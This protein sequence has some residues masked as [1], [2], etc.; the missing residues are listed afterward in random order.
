MLLSVAPLPSHSPQNAPGFSCR[1]PSRRRTAEAEV[2]K[3]STF[4]SA[5]SLGFMRELNLSMFNV[6]FSISNWS[7]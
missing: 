5:P 4:L 6:Q 7:Y 2:A 3:V 1:S